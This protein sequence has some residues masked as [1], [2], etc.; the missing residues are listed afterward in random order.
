MINN[1]LIVFLHVRTCVLL[2][3]NIPFTKFVSDGANP[4][5]IVSI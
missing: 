5:Y 2:M 1:P 4:Y 3:R